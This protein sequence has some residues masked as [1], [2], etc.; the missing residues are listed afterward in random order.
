MSASRRG[1]LIV[2]FCLAAV[3]WPDSSATAQ[4]Y[5]PRYDGGNAQVVDFSQALA[6]PL[7]RFAV[8]G[9]VEHPGV[10][11]TNERKVVRARLLKAAGSRAAMGDYYTT[12]HRGLRSEPMALFDAETTEAAHGDV[13]VVGANAFR[14]RPDDSKEIH[15]AVIGLMPDP[16]VVRLSARERSLPVLL[17]RLRQRQEAATGATVN[18]VASTAPL[19]N[20]D[21]VA[22]NS[23]LI[24]RVVL[25]EC[26]DIILLVRE[27]HPSSSKSTQFEPSAEPH[28]VRVAELPQLDLPVAASPPAVVVSESPVAAQGL[29]TPELPFV[30]PPTLVEAPSALVADSPE[31][32][33]PAQP[34]RRA[35]TPRVTTA[36]HQVVDRW[37][38]VSKR[39]AA[40]NED[41]S[42]R[43]LVIFVALGTLGLGIALLWLASERR[44]KSV[45]RPAPIP[46]PFAEQSPVD[47]PDELAQLI[48]GE[49]EIEDEPVVLPSRIALHG[50]AVGQKR[51]IVHPPEALAGPH[52]ASSPAATEKARVT[53]SAIE[54]G[55]VRRD[56]ETSVKTPV[57]SARDTEGLLDRVLLAMQREGR[58]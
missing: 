16:V 3:H 10:Y 52:F 45:E 7:R 23:H 43:T 8:I 5:I 38:V 51:L 22:F 30:S 55:P 11:E 49:L 26:G 47:T 6:P 36:D 18:G 29:R 19:R 34:S 58:K 27:L 20:G 44:F 2:A 56:S 31:T 32:A 14:G 50:Q 4:T 17:N 41:S 53:Q 25:Q 57:R 9:D 21:V 48:R 39:T 46:V 28:E 1:F 42:I 40:V 12:H 54:D 13:I 35:A 15:V 37:P 24:D 33:A